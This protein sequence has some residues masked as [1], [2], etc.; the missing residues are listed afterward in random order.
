MLSLLSQELLSIEDLV[1]IKSLK[2]L[3]KVK[4]LEE[5][6][7]VVDVFNRGVKLLDR[8]DLTN[9]L[10]GV[11]LEGADLRVADLRGADLEEANL[12]RAKLEGANLRRS[13]LYK[14]NLREADLYK[15]NLEG[16]L[17]IDESRIGKNGVY[18]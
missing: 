3:G 1:Y 5:D 7:Y 13:Y 6:K 12:I 11:D 17:G 9:N 14:A 8:E 4:G 16:T 18:I 2:T 15:A 10:I